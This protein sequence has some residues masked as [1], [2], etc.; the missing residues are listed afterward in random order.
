MKARVLNG[1]ALALVIATGLVGILYGVIALEPTVPLNPFPPPVPTAT[2][3]GP[4]EPEETATPVPTPTPFPTPT[5][6]RPAPPTPT[7]EPSYPFTATVETGPPGGTPDCRATL[8]GVILDRE[9]HGL[10]GY[11]VHLWAAEND[12]AQEDM[13]LFSDRD[14]RWQADLPA[15]AR[16]LWYVQLH[17]PDARQVYPP[18]SAV[19]AVR[20]PESCAQAYITFHAS[21]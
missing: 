8:R 4:P 11:P 15:G 21:H 20:L 14:G 6:L 5:A 12:L 3:V 17:A 7:P 13:I 2:P 9:G 18:L 19:V 16:G 1:L 10:E